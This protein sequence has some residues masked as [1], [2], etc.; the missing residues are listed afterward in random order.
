MFGK[1]LF[2]FLK[3]FRHL[4]AHSLR[5]SGTMALLCAQVDTDII[6][7]LGRWHSD[8]MLCYLHLLAEPVMH[9]FA[10]RMLNHG[11]FVLHPN[12][13]EVPVY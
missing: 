1:V 5:D 9:N 11:N 7:P 8:E 4:S 13:D 2:L 12:H 6:R 10:S 3:V